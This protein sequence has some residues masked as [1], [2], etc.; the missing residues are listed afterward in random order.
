MDIFLNSK[1]SDDLIE[2]IPLSGV[3]K[4]A[5]YIGLSGLGSKPSK[6][7]TISKDPFSCESG[8]DDD[9]VD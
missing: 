7:N 1:R 5:A 3:V 9:A 2:R 8:S 4:V 6:S